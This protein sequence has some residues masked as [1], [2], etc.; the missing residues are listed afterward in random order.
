MQ[1]CLVL[2]IFT[3][4]FEMYLIV[5]YIDGLVQCGIHEMKNEE[6]FKNGIVALTLFRVRVD[7]ILTLG[8]GGLG[9]RVVVVVVVVV[10][11]G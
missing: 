11:V 7:E 4:D 10:V 1:C 8:F 2:V 5:V 3:V 9:L 6:A